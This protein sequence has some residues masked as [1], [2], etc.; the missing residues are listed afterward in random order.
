MV[1]MKG[2][3]VWVAFLIITAIS[4][5][6]I[7]IVLLTIQPTYKRFEE[8]TRIAEGMG[9]LRLLDSQINYLIREG[10]G[11]RKFPI[12]ITA[13]EYLIDS[14]K[15][16]IEFLT[17]LEAKVIEPG[18][19]VRQD[20]IT[21]TS[22]SRARAWENASHLILENDLVRITF[23]KSASFFRIINEIFLKKKAMAIKP[24]NSSIIFN[25]DPSLSIAASSSLVR[26]GERLAKAEALFNSSSFRVIFTLLSGSDY[27]VAR[28]IGSKNFTL[29][30]LFYLG[31]SS[32]DDIVYIPE[33]GSGNV[34][35]FSSGCW[36]K[37]NLPSYYYICSDDPELMFSLIYLGKRPLFREICF[38]NTSL[39]NYSLNL[40]SSQRIVVAF[41]TKK[42]NQLSE[43]IKIN[44]EQEVPSSIEELPPTEEKRYE[45]AIFR[46]YDTIDIANSARLRAGV[47]NVCIKYVGIVDRKPSIEILPC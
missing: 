33:I 5:T 20:E 18:L 41:L 12:S 23:N 26:K 43:T 6:G 9:N 24:A 28:V 19:L 27:M 42:C 34:S 31:T 45:V 25:S 2:I 37:D 10:G 29:N 40:T 16:S 8:S 39:G 15:D 36:S 3:S 30:I 46:E 17:E 4:L 47:R 35:N 7:I 44:E 11:S 38:S 32:S 21:I 14:D 13:G 22:G 1:G